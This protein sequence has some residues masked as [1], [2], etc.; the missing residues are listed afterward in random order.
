MASPSRKLPS[1]ARAVVD[2]AK[3]TEYL[4]NASHP[5]NG[6]K[7]RFFESIGF[8][9]SEPSLLVGALRTIAIEG[10]TV[11]ATT[12]ARSTL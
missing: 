2:L 7:A 5:D 9:P 1:G 4:L 11:Q 3:V 10:E 8:G 12:S 6:G